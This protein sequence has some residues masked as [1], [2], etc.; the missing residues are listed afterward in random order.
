MRYP[1]LSSLQENLYKIGI[2]VVFYRKDGV[3]ISEFFDR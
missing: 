1:E 2:G 3:E